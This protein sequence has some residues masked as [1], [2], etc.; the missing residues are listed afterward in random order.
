MN[1]RILKEVLLAF[2]VILISAL[3]FIN[4]M[5]SMTYMV[6]HSLLVVAFGFFALYVWRTKAIDERDYY[7]RTLSA[8]GAFIIGGLFSVIAIAYQSFAHYSID[9]WLFVILIV[10][11]LSRILISIYLNRHN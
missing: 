10:M 3:C 2:G 5:P 7:H 4:D 9:P 6:I 11:I 8:E 1:K